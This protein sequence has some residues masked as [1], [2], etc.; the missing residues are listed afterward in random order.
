M[1]H[2]LNWHYAAR[3]LHDRRRTDVKREYWQIHLVD[4]KRSW[5]HG[6]SGFWGLVLQD[7]ALPA[8]LLGAILFEVFR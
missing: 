3:M 5:E 1:A 4:R 6:Q 8:L 7:L 2:A